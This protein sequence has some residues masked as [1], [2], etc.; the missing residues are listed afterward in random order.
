VDGRATRLQRGRLVE[1][2]EGVRPSPD[3]CPSWSCFNGAASSTRRKASIASV[4][5][6]QAQAA[7][8]GAASSRRR[9]ADAVEVLR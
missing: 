7:S 1:E 4:D 3:G 5:V 8:N 2:A 9:K 6:A